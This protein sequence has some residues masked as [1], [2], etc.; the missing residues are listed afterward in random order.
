[1]IDSATLADMETP[2]S[3]SAPTTLALTIEEAARELR[4]SPLTVR[5][6]VRAGK[7]RGVWLG[8]RWRVPRDEL[9]RLL[10]R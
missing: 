8:N 10:S 5:R 2:I 7:L 6:W 9:V 4:L 3:V 1:M